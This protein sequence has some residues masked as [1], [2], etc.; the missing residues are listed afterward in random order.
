MIDNVLDVR[1]TDSDEN[2]KTIVTVECEPNALHHVR[3]QFELA[4]DA[5]DIRFLANDLIELP[6]DEA[7]EQFDKLVDALE[8]IDDVQVVSHNVN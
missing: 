4:P 7:Y 8:D 1:K 6:N 2:E 3:Q 5:I